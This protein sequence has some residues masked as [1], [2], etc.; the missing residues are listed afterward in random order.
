MKQFVKIVGI[1]LLAVVLLL[2]GTFFYLQRPSG[3]R[4][5]TTQVTN[6]L[7]R[8]VNQPFSIEKIRY[9]IPD[10]IALEGVY[11]SD[12]YGDTLLAGQKLYVDID[13]MELLKN[14]VA[15]NEIALQ[16]IKLNIKRTLPDTTFNFTKLLNAFQSKES[17]TAVSD[18][19]TSSPFLYHI[20]TINLKNVGINYR[21]DISGVEAKTFIKKTKTGFDAIAPNTSTYHLNQLELEE[22]NLTL[23]LYDPLKKV[24]SSPTV[25][26]N[27][28]LD[29]AFGTL[30]LRKINWKITD[31]TSGLVNTVSLGR[32]RSKGEKL[33]LANENIHLKSL[34]LF[35][36]T[37]SVKFLKKSQKIVKSTPT[38]STANNW[39][40]LIDK[41]VLDQNTI[42]YQD[43]NAPFL[44][45]GIDFNN[46]KINNLK[47]NSERFYYSPN[48]ISGWIFSS[49][50]NEKSG[51]QLQNLQTDFAYTNKQMFLKKFLLKTPKSILRDELVMNYKSQDD[52]IKD[53]G[54]TSIKTSLKNS[55]LAFQ[56]I[57]WLVPNLA[58]TPPFKGNAQEIL[59]FNGLLTGKINN[60]KITN[61]TFSAF[62]QTKVRFNGQIM[63]LPNVEQTALNLNVSEIGLTKKDLMRMVPSEMIPQNIDLPQKIALTG[64]IDGKINDLNLNT[65]LKS[66]LGNASFKGKLIN[67]TANKNQQY[68]GEI[69]L[70]SFEM[71]KFLK[72]TEQLGKLS[73][74]AKINGRGIDPKTMNA[75]V[76]GLIQEA[77]IKGYN[78]KNMALVGSLANQIAQIKGNINDPNVSLAINT[79]F[80][81][82]QE[83]P[84]I[85]GNVKIN[86]LNLK[87]LGLYSN[88]MTIKGDID[89]DLP[90]SNPENPSGKVV[91][92]QG[93]LYNNGK[94]IPLNNVTLI[95]KNI[96]NEKQIFMD[97]PFAK[98]S[99]K[100]NFNY[101][102]LSD[103]FINTINRY[104][105]IPDI[106]AQ[107][108]TNPYSLKM[109]IK[110]VKHP[111]LQAFVPNLSR[112][113]TT[114]FT[115]NIDS[116]SGTVLNASLFMPFAEYDTIQ[117][118]NVSLNMVGNDKSLTYKGQLD[119]INFDG[120]KVRKSTITGD[121]ANNSANFKATFKDSLN[122]DRHEIAGILQNIDNQYRINLNRRGL[123][124]NYLPWQVDSSGYFQYGKT[125]LLAHQFLINR[126]EQRLSVHSPSGIPNSPLTIQ[127]DSL[128]I[129][130]FISLFSSDSTLAG[131][132]IDGK[133]L[134]SNFMESPSFTGD[135]GIKNFQFQKITIGD[136]AVNV[137]NETA[138][139]ITTKASIL[140][141]NNDIQLA[142]NYYLNTKNPL[143]LNL[144][145]NKLGAETVEAFSF[146]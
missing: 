106:A 24:E 62:N 87:P 93:T 48:Q 22:S 97:A 91:I 114:H 71:G 108:I 61:A 49:S 121:V 31:E 107:P 64:K 83:F 69:T 134:L 99:L 25:Q 105:V 88:N 132:K 139:K 37:A 65:Q 85:K 29:L 41:I 79:A 43:F 38:N 26:T 34:E 56:D 113:D 10:W 145:I 7:K 133:I 21:D 4:F 39:R 66:D 89:I 84:G 74:N 28:T 54:Q 8:T 9:K 45:K 72:Q 6:Y 92:N 101:L 117:I 128:D 40:V 35:N 112:L 77:E 57:L 144:I 52:L 96:L 16:N 90:V 63:G 94:P 104:F 125:G 122:K 131:G 59:K 2:V 58:N 80:D 146:G 73:L 50:F 119:G 102:Q 60:L 27:D 46:L 109:D 115:A 30:D 111:V 44:S 68:N 103:I 18:T 76:E 95:A 82:S 129:E 55:Q 51:F 116:Q 70:N 1:V 110:L 143:D 14:K 67:I 53:I 120:F 142:G 86:E 140:G 19:A 118:N 36:T 13:M 33:S 124:V 42:Q 78:Y 135:L 47:L 136:V 15:I 12:N 126:G 75:S 127:T 20:S 32:L 81:I 137:F 138:T 98:A 5:L 141:V 23:R 11:F 130:N 100:G 17:S 3:Q 123:L